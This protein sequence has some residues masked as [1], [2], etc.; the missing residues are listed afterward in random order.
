MGEETTGP[1]LSVPQG[2]KIGGAVVA[3]LL[4]VWAAVLG[5]RILMDRSGPPEFPAGGV[6][7]WATFA[8]HLVLGTPDGEDRLDITTVLWSRQGAH[9]IN[10]RI[11][12]AA[13]MTEG[14]AYAV[15][16][17]W[18]EDDDGGDDGRWVALSQ[19]A[20]VRLSEGRIAGAGDTWAEHH[21]GEHPRA[22][23]SELYETGPYP[24][25]VPH[26][27]ESLR[28]RLAAVE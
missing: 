21:L 15:P 7:D 24:A 20:V 9:P 8:D 16:V 12:V 19:D 17:A 5:G 10:R 14:E 18:L 6:R 27:Y 22:L 25:A 11:T 4:A 28:Q 2:V 3:I 13:E 1:T 23:A 26:L